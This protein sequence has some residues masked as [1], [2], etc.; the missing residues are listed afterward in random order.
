MRLRERL[1]SSLPTPPHDRKAQHE[2][3]PFSCD[4]EPST[5][6]RDLTAA[7][8]AAALH[9]AV[10]AAVAGHDAAAGGAAGAVAHVDHRGHGRG[11]VVDAA[12]GDR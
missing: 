6:A 7:A 11:G 3:G 9:A 5:S 2:A 1:G 4:V 12:V 8:G 10:A